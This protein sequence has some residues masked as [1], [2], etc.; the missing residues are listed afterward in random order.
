MYHS[1]YVSIENGMVDYKNHI[2]HDDII[3]KRGENGIITFLEGKTVII[4]YISAFIK[5]VS[6]S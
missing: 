5:K 2:G 6:T 1:S 3:T 4:D